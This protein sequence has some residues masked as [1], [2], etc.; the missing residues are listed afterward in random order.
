VAGEFTVRRYGAFINSIQ[1]EIADT[2]RD[3]D[4]KRS[5]VIEDLAFAHRQL[6][7]TPCFVVSSRPDAG[8]LEVQRPGVRRDGHPACTRPA[9]P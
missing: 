7:S 6:R 8:G 2:I 3:D 5:F 9:R 4:Q 1:I